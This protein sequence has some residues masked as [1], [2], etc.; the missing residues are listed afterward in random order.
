MPPN[1]ERISAALRRDVAQRAKQRCEYCL[2]P[3]EFS[4]NSF[5]ID[6]IYLRVLGGETAFGNLAW[7]CFG[8]NGRKHIKTE[9]SD[10]DT[11]VTTKLF[12]P[13]KQ[14]WLA[15]FT[16]D[17][18]ENTFIVEKTACGRA[19]TATLSLNRTG[20]VNLRKLLKSVGSHPPSQI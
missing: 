19:T 18:A 14:A 20:V 7:A 13:R 17:E 4:P 11:G 9:G 8:C 12:H 15:H 5:T 2:C 10:L 1:P 3:D 16:W 6:H